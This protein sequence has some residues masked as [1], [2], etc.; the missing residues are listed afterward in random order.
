MDGQ[1]NWFSSGWGAKEAKQARQE[2]RKAEF[3]RKKEEGD[4]RRW[5]WVAVTTPEEDKSRQIVFLDDFDWKT[6]KGNDVVPFCVR[7][8]QVVQD[9]DWKNPLH[10]P[11]VSER[12]GCVL[13]A[14]KY[15]TQFVGIFSVLD[16]A[17]WNDKE[18]GE[19]IV[20][21][22]PCVLPAV[23][24]AM[25]II[26]SRYVKLGNLKGRLFTVARHDSKAARV[27]SDYQH[28]GLVEDIPA[29]LKEHDLWPDDPEYSLDLR[30]Y[31]MSAEEAVD[32]YREMFAPTPPDKL[33][34]MIASG[35]CSDGLDWYRNKKGGSSSGS[36]SDDGVVDYDD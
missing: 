33:R 18:T 7:F 34:E 9:G 6:P 32:F 14:Q 15:R 13:C 19:R 27:G 12:G 35:N 3:E 22:R 29:Y 10:E 1:Q 26:K 23:M 5:F 28:E 16:I 31:G 8:H 11:C 4:K 21:P 20:R 17:Q 2:Q 24:E 25:N 36:S 30:P